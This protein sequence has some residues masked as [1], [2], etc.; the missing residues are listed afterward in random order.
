MAIEWSTK[1][2]IA[3][4]ISYIIK[5]LDTIIKQNKEMLAKMD[6]GKQDAD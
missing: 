3:K 2:E 5:Q 4:G 6:G 1:A